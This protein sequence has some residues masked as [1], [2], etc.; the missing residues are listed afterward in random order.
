[1]TSIQSYSAASSASD[2][3]TNKIN[4]LFNQTDTDGS[5][6][7]SQSEFAA[8][9]QNLPGASSTT[10]NSGTSSLFSQIDTDGDGSIS[11]DEL[12]AYA[13]QQQTQAQQALLSLQ[14]L[15]G[16]GSSSAT[17]GHHGH[18]HHHGGQTDSTASTTGSDS[19]G[20]DGS[21]TSTNPLDALFQAM[22]GNGDGSLSKDELSSY[23]AQYTKA[24][25]AA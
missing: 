16:S 2:Y 1:M 4:T 8:I 24:A 11:K 21:T 15:F 22:D 3:F 23:L 18:H 9:G 14:E 20:A 25:S 17:S 12:S 6:G 19:S 10:G 5:G 13:K 7:I